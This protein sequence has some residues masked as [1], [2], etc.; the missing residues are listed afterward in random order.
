MSEY[1]EYI[2][3]DKKAYVRIY[4]D[5]AFVAVQDI[6]ARLH[7]ETVDF[8]IKPLLT[9][10]KITRYAAAF[11]KKTVGLL[12]NR[13]KKSGIILET[14]GVTIC[15]RLLRQEHITDKFKEELLGKLIKI[16]EER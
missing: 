2:M 12:L 13:Y 5:A 14:D 9:R 4:T 1:D 10:S 7:F 3:T 6:N 8:S 15:H 16:F 11:E